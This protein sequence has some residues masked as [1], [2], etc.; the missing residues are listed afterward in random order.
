MALSLSSLVRAQVGQTAADRHLRRARHRQ[1][2]PRRRVPRPDLHPDRG[3]RRQPR[4]HHLRRRPAH[5]RGRGRR[6]DRAAADRR[7]Q[8]PDGG[9]RQPRLVRADALGGGL[10]AQQVDSDRGRGLRQG[11]RR[12]R[13]R[14]ALLPRPDERAPR[15]ARHDSDHAGA[16]GDQDLLRSRARQLRPL[17]PAPAQARRRDGGRA[18]RRRRLHELRHHHPEGEG[19]VQQGD[20]QGLRRRPAHAVPDRAARLHRQEPLRHARQRC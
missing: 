2:Q 7:P 14:L 16:R 8:V 3:G 1:D 6:G 20:R 17:P 11:L 9:S 15:P 5:Q 4:A 12:R 13:C 19:R 10:Q 18:R